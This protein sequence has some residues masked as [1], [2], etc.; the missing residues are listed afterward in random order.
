[1][2]Y[3]QVGSVFVVGVWSGGRLTEARRAGHLQRVQLRKLKRVVHGGA[4]REI[5][6]IIVGD[7]VKFV[8]ISVMLLVTCTFW[9]SRLVDDQGA[10]GVIGS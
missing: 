1:M 9:L 7:S 8:H 6:I 2:E 10:A 5:K 4:R 3:G